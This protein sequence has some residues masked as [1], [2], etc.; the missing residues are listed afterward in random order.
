MSGATHPEGG[1]RLPAERSSFVGR[2]HELAEIR[3][4]LSGSRVVT[5]VGSG[6][7]GKTRLAIRAA[8]ELQRSFPGGAPCAALPAV[9]DPAQVA[10]Q[11]AA[12][13][14]VR[15]VSGRWLPAG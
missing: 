1:P 8:H 4:L 9:R 15:D 7:V 13:L 11:V 2:R 3:R 14:D 12:A 10:P 6:G 5:L